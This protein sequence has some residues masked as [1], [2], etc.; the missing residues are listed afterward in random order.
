LATGLPLAPPAALDLLEHSVPLSG[1]GRD[2]LRPVASGVRN[3][4]IAEQ[5]A[6]S[7][8]AVKFHV[9]KPCSPRPARG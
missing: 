7:E 1:R 6:I 3:R 9:V 5:L 4:A 2:V 8:N